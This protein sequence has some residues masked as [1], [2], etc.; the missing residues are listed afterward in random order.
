MTLSPRASR[1]DSTERHGCPASPDDLLHAGDV[2]EDTFEIRGKIG[3]GGMG[4]VYEAHDRRLGRRV[5]VKVGFPGSEMSVSGEARALAALRPHPSIVTVHSLGMHDGLEYAVMVRI[6]GVTLEVYLERR[7]SEG[8]RIGIPELVDI[9]A[10]I[11]EGLAVVHD[12]GMAHRDVKPANVILAP[13]NRVVI[14]DFGIFKPECDRTRSTIVWGTPEYVAPEAV[15]DGIAPGELFLVDVYAL[16]ILLFQM[17]TDEVPFRSTSAA[18]TL[19]MQVHEP[20][21]DPTLQRLD[22]P[23]DL[24]ALVREMMAKSPSARPQGMHEV[25]W[26]L[27]RLRDEPMPSSRRF[28]TLIAEDNAA[29][30]A[31]LALLVGEGARDGEVRFARDGLV[32]LQMVQRR[33]PDLL[34]VDLH[35]P[36]MSGLELCQRV[37]ATDLARCCRIVGTS[38]LAERSELDDLRRLGSVQYLPKGEECSAQLPMLA[39]EAWAGFRRR[40]R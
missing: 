4:Q 31:I 3:E 13:G 33:L 11:A 38:A 29:T 15:T 9:A 18:G 32:A 19:W 17:L 26:R 7:R 39:R 30:A 1:T 28:S 35:L 23:R 10:D 12:A 16:G 20:I 24:A 6:H 8:T 21:P 5:A 36:G 40:S 34:V 22:T 25:A 14:M 27:R 2:L 37:T